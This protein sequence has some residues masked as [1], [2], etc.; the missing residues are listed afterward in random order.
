MCPSLSALQ[1]K[2]QMLNNRHNSKASPPTSPWVRLHW[3]AA[4]VATY[5]GVLGWEG[6]LGIGRVKSL[7]FPISISFQDRKQACHCH[8]DF[9]QVES[10]LNCQPFLFRDKLIQATPL[11]CLL[12]PVSAHN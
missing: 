7:T 10:R 2:T 11:K 12:S 8:L 4:L 1:S 6:N 9:C 3:V 5:Q